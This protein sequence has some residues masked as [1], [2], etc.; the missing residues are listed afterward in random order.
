MT[1]Q[2]AEVNGNVIREHFA[3]VCQT[4][5][6]TPAHFVWNMDAMRQDQR[7]IL[8]QYQAP[9]VTDRSSVD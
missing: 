8:T 9:C 6:G 4:V 7:E 3:T 5:S 2:M 1:E